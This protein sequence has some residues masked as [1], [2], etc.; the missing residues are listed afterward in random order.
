MIDFDVENISVTCGLYVAKSRFL[1]K[2]SS[3]YDG[4]MSHVSCQREIMDR[5]GRDIR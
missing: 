1:G 3:C 2:T 5:S 4:L